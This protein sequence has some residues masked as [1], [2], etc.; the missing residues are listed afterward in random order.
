MDEQTRAEYDAKRK[1]LGWS[2]DQMADFIENT[3]GTP[4]PKLAAEMR[5]QAE[6]D[7]KPKRQSA[8]RGRSGKPK[9]TAS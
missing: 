4:D 2:W 5:K 8:P 3:V 6:G 1:S 7:D 9:D